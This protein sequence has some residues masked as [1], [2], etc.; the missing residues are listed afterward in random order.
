MGA[1]MLS[2]NSLNS[3]TK[4]FT[5]PKTSRLRVLAWGNEGADTASSAGLKLLWYSV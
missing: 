4:K 1:R 3:P 2:F 5:D